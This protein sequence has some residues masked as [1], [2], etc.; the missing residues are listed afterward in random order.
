MKRNVPVLGLI[1]GIIFPILGL[2][3]LYL[4]TFDGSLK[5]YFQYL[6]VNYKR[7]TPGMISLSLMAN[8]IP[9]IFY[10]SKRLDLTARGILI[11]TM[12]YAVLIVLIKFV[13]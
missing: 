2:L 7:A 13:W 11:A 9:F 10:T 12:L 3:L 1:L 4:I 8:L 6:V 5:E